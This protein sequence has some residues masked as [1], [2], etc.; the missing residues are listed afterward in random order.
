[1][2]PRQKRPTEEEVLNEITDRDRSEFPVVTASDV[3]ELGDYDVSQRTI[4]NRLESL[5]ADGVLQSREAGRTMIY[6]LEEDINSGSDAVVAS[7][8]S[9]EGVEAEEFDS[10]F[11]IETGGGLSPIATFFADHLSLLL[12]TQE[13]RA[14]IRRAS[15]SLGVAVAAAVVTVLGGFA[16]AVYSNGSGAPE[17]LIT[18]MAFAMVIFLIAFLFGLGELGLL[19]SGY[20]TDDVS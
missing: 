14:A 8:D 3:L 1:M 16:G 18:G 10:G 11:K 19:K 7:E 17:L 4:A 6:W 13:A 12:N 5:V 9:T 2:T 15:V 20:Y